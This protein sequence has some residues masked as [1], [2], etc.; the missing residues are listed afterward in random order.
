MRN[1]TGQGVNGDRAAAEESQQAVLTWALN[2]ISKVFPI[3]VLT[4]LCIDIDKCCLARV[5]VG[6]LLCSFC[7]RVQVKPQAISEPSAKPERSF[8]HAG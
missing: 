6:D 2:P 7:P 3:N 4:S 8:V 5:F 1:A